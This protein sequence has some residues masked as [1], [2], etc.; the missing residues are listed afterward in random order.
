MG[1]QTRS[2]TESEANTTPRAARNRFGGGVTR[3]RFVL[4]AVM[5][6]AIA[7]LAGGVGVTVADTASESDDEVDA[8][9]EID[10]DVMDV[11]GTTY[12]DGT[13]YASGG[14]TVYAID[15][16][17]GE[18][19]WNVSV[20]LDVDR[21]PAVADGTVY[22]GS[23][24]G[25]WTGIEDVYFYAVD[26]ETGEEE[27][28][29]NIGAN[30]RTSPAVDDG[31]VYFGSWDNDLHALDA[32]TGDELWT[33][34]TG[35]N[36]NSDP[37]V[38]DGVVYFASNDEN[39]YAVDATSGQG[40]WSYE[41][42][43]DPASRSVAVA[44][45]TVYLTDYS[46]VLHAVDA[47]DGSEEWTV[48]RGWY[49]TEPA[50]GEGLVVVAG[51]NDPITA[52]DAETGEEMWSRSSERDTSQ[53]VHDGTVYVGDWDEPIVRGLDAGSGDTVWTFDT[54]GWGAVP[55]AIA[56]DVLYASSD[57]TLHA[58]PTDPRAELEV[59]DV[60]LSDTD[61]RAD[62]AVTVTVDV[63]NTGTLPGEH[64]VP[65]EI[66]GERVN[67]T[68]ATVDPGETETVSF[69]VEFD[70]AGTYDVAAGGLEAGAVTVTD[71]EPKLEV[72]QPTIFTD[73]TQGAVMNFGVTVENVDSYT[74]EEIP[75]VVEVFDEVQLEEEIDELGPGEDEYFLVEVNTATIESGEYEWRVEVG[76][77]EPLSDSFT[78]HPLDLEVSQPTIFDDVT[79][80]AVMNFGV[81][82]EN[83]DSYTGEE[84]PVVVEVF[85][86]VQLEE[87]IDELAPDEDEYFLVE[88]DTT[89]IDPG[90]YEWRVDVGEEE[91]LA[92]SF[93]LHPLDLEVSQPTIF[94]DV[95][96]GAVMNFGVTVENTDSYTGEEIPVVV[97]V[98]DEVQVE[99]TIDE[100]GPGED[101][102]F[103]V[104]VDTATIESGEYEWRVEVGEEEPLSDSFT[105]HPLD[106]D[107]SQPTIFDDVTQGAIMNFGVTVE[108]T[109]SYTGED[110]PVV[111]EVFDEVQL[112][113]EIDE[114]GPGEEE[115]FLVEVNTA[116]VESGEYEWRVE[117]G[118][119]EPLSDSFTLH[120]LDLEVSQPTIFTDVT[121]GAVMNFGVTVENTDSYTGEEIPVTVEVFDEVQ[122][123]ETIDELAPG[124]DEYFLVEVDTATVE[125]GEYEWRVEAG[126]AEPLSDSFTL[127]PL[128]LEVSQPTIFTDVT[129][130]AVMN[131]GVTVENVDSYTGEEIPVVVE[132]FDEVQVDEEIAELSP[133][134]DEYFLVEV[135]TAT[136]D[137]GEYEWRVE[138]GEKEPLS[139]SFTLV[140]V[141]R[142]DP[143]IDWIWMDGHADRADTV[144][145]SEDVP[146]TVRAE[147]P[148]GDVDAVDLELDSL[149]TTWTH[150]IEATHDDG[151][152]WTATIDLEAVPDDGAYE[153]AVQAVD[154]EGNTAET[155]AEEILE[156]DREP[157]ELAATVGEIDGET[158]TVTVSSDADLD[159][160]P[161]ILLEYPD[162]GS[163]DAFLAEDDGRWTTVV[164]IDGNGAYAVTAFG[165]DLAGNDA[166]ADATAVVYTDLTLEAGDVL[167]NPRTGTTVEF[168]TNESVPDAS[169]AISEGAFA[170]HPLA[171]DQL[172]VTFL[173]ADLGAG[174]SDRL[175]NATI[176]VPVDE[177][178]MAPVDDP[179]TVSLARYDE[180][181]GEW[182][183][184]ETT[185]ETIDD[186]HYWVATVDRFSTYGAIATD[187]RAPT[188]ETTPEDGAELESDTDEVTVT[189]EYADD[190][191]GV[192]PSSVSLSV[193]GVDVT[194]ADGT[195][196]TSISVVHTLA[197]EAGSGYDLEVTVADHAGNDR[198]VPFSFDVASPSS[199]QG[200]GSS[201]GD[202]SIGSGAES[203]ETGPDDDVAD[204]TD[205]VNEEDD[206]DEMSVDDEA[207][208]DDV[209]PE[210]GDD[211]ASVS[212]DDE[213]QAVDDETDGSVTD[214]SDGSSADDTIPGFG[215]TAAIVALLG[216]AALAARSR[217]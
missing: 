135:D 168:V 188:I 89:T 127:H 203:G 176:R 214:D 122:V 170:H 9:W 163:E 164:D 61:V 125:S 62:E 54:G 145:A 104:E 21:A 112:E 49:P 184:V 216:V 180:T 71:A 174:L 43:Y 65:L 139:D 117:A 78:L 124:E 140:P 105:L 106:L 211:D 75:V 29:T 186:E 22:F 108:N 173:T 16:T 142:P 198:T 132:V 154:D 209:S 152:Y 151:D 5:L 103:L 175:E 114:L 162:G 86:E 115:F 88:V 153:L 133:D 98:F 59:V 76:E 107:V 80:G 90:E 182:E 128:D 207:E 72:S 130:G 136:I 210:D 11:A 33:Y 42:D 102:Y 7:L 194:E 187:D 143:E 212:D 144:Y 116:T 92:D 215:L 45:G 199:G 93:T 95:T 66:D 57:G 134:E 67:T 8:L 15:A 137:P 41:M 47:E 100:L 178:A 6:V 201:G 10:L 141:D 63:E 165:T 126:E 113:E 39:I 64:V 50:T 94:T 121:Q 60:T 20:L 13:V 4:T 12:H 177:S 109:D 28:S 161:A 205:E 87:E 138:V 74:G 185:V 70:D 99:E 149:E 171:D 23:D 19:R 157:P 34:S 192:D 25:T 58:V 197:V 147:A 190:L 2:G 32:D 96:Q 169:A 206:S 155:T 179:E 37:A 208:S 159:E 36:V 150:E 193:D 196:I 146:V 195:A 68:L 40:L 26:A 52:F 189:V 51:R 18:E 77:E 97:E 191:T 118:E 53:F 30:V 3:D 73:V 82:V 110:I 79:Q 31:V 1:R 69:S 119:A 24:R 84:I 202:S 123:D 148:F 217:S 48:E 200:S 85:D 56:D 129:Q 27:W 44:D 160:A 35:R 181:A 111:V 213:E 120:P 91:P 167:E 83:T 131:F 38:V 172:G 183:P 101:E 17:T 55:H 14:N 158:A 46:G 166:S 156:I 204:E 81:T